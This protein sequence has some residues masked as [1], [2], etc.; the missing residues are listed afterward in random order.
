M[1]AIHPIAALL[2]FLAVVSPG[3]TGAVVTDDEKKT[4]E[5][6]ALPPLPDMIPFARAY[7]LSLRECGNNGGN[8]PRSED[9]GALWT[10][11]ASNGCLKLAASPTNC[12]QNYHNNSQL[13]LCGEP[14]GWP[15]SH[16]NFT[17]NHHVGTFQQDNSSL[18]LSYDYDRDGAIPDM[19]SAG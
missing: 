16:Y 13:I 1:H 6:S 17:W 12:L 18:C 5:S 10:H 8:N 2:V 9:L 19:M 11:N 4:K 7:P 3:A 14:W 15:V